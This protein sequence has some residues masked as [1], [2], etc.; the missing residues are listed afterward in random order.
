MA[1]FAGTAC[2][3]LDC[4]GYLGTG[5]NLADCNGHGYCRSMSSLATYSEDNGDL[6]GVVYT[7]P[8]DANKVYGC[9]CTDAHHG[10]FAGTYTYFSGHDCSKKSCPTGDDPQTWGGAHETQIVTC[11]ADSGT[12]TLTFRQ[13]TTVDIAYDATASTV[14]A[15]LKKTLRKLIGLDGI[16]ALS[17]GT[18]APHDLTVTFSSGTAACT[19]DGSNGMSVTF[20]T[21]LGDVP[22][23]TANAGSLTLTAS[24]AAVVVEE[25][26]PGTYENVEC[27]N[28]GKCSYARGVCQCFVGYDSSDGSGNAGERGDCGLRLL[29]PTV[30]SAFAESA[31]PP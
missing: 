5:G 1:G 17:S 11:T 21:D 25:R 4:G 2:E 22:L 27:G 10:P 12:F 23:M 6:R 15:E 7:T 26:I 31:A 3:Y 16:D 28:K 30:Y 8:W 18:Y 14:R 29:Y 20:K 19:A 13:R 9:Q 24:T